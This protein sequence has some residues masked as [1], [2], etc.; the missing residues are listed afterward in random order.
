VTRRKTVFANPT[1][2][3]ATA[4]KRTATPKRPARLCQGL[5][6]VVIGAT[7]SLGAAFATSTGSTPSPKHP[8]SLTPVARPASGSAFR[9][10]CHW[11]PYGWFC[12]SG[13]TGTGRLIDPFGVKVAR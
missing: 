10:D 5:A 12:S 11:R 1:A 3:N 2:L 8:I 9:P 13:P 7:L 4:A 6:A